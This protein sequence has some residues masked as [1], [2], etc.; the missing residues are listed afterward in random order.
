MDS[1]KEII[2]HQTTLIV[3]T[4][5]EI[6]E[7]NTTRLKPPFVDI[8][9]KMMDSRGSLGQQ[10]DPSNGRQTPRKRPELCSYQHLVVICRPK[11]QQK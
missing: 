7:V 4:K 10:P 1:L 3:T 2:T 9:D 11:R 5:A 8:L 6:L